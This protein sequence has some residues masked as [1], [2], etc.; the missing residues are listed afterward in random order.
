MILNNKVFNPGE[1]RTKITLVRSSVDKVT[2]GQKV[3]WSVDA[4]VYCKWVNAHGSE[5][6]VGG[7]MEATRPATLM[8]RYYANLEAGWGV[9]K[10]WVDTVSSGDTVYELVAPPDD[11]RERHEYMAVTVRMVEGSV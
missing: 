8:M 2:G 10:G 3:T 9:L 11:I 4:K 7:A 6:I 1:M 5:A